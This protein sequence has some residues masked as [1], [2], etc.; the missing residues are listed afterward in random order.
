MFG[1][2]W[3]SRMIIFVN[4]ELPRSLYLKM[5]HG[6]YTSRSSQPRPRLSLSFQKHHGAEPIYLNTLVSRNGG[7]HSQVK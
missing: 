3:N 4:I 2:K 7:L 1:I 5:Q 6:L